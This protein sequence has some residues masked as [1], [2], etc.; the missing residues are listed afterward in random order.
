MKR[1]YISVLIML[2]LLAAA[3]FAQDQ[4]SSAARDGSTGDVPSPPSRPLSGAEAESTFTD[5]G[6]PVSG[7]VQ[8]NF[9]LSELAQAGGV[10]NGYRTAI[11]GA[12]AFDQASAHRTFRLQYAGGVVFDTRNQNDNQNFHNL[13]VAEGFAVGRWDLLLGDAFSYLPQAPLT[14]GWAYG[15]PGWGILSPFGT[16]NPDLLPSE[17]ILTF[18]TQR[19]NNASFAQEQYHFTPSTSVTSVISYGLLRYLDNALLNSYQ[20]VATTG[21]DHEMRRGKAGVKYT[22]SR[23]AYDAISG[24]L[25]AHA[26]ELMFAQPIGKDFSAEIS[27]GPQLVRPHALAIHGQVVG[28]GNAQL[29]YQRRDYHA[30]VR[31]CRGANNGSG[32]LIGA[33]TDSVEAR[34]RRRFR[35]WTVE[36]NGGYR[37]NSGVTQSA[38]LTNHQFGAQLSREVSATVGTYLSYTY[39]AQSAG[40]WC[41][42]GSCAFNDNLHTVSFGFYWHPRGWWVSH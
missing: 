20:L 34:V 27:A 28:A 38:R 23:F 6:A 17:S 10:D 9:A 16:I 22:Y 5:E 25:E 32:L 2:L 26:V 12:L 21:L 19:V 1:R 39:Q 15:M 7:F 18:R 35:I 4:P 31:Y 41:V 30:S 33:W 24:G 29:S 3:A 36:T 11:S 14:S 42:A 40:S 8:P 37:R 13:N